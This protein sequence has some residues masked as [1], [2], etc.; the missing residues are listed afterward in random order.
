MRM[1]HDEH[2]RGYVANLNEVLDGTEWANR[3]LER[4]LADLDLLPEDKRTSVRNNGDD[5][6]SHTL[7]WEIMAP[8]GGGDPAGPLGDAIEAMFQSVRELKRQ[9]SAAGVAR[10]GSGWI[11]LMHDG[12]GLA[13]TYTPNQDSLPMNGH[14]PLLGV[15]V[16]GHAYY[17]KYQHRRADYLEAWWNVV[18]WERAADRYLTATGQSRQ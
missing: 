8:D 7:F 9:V 1:H 17:L 12:A 10:F 6:A 11:W 15:D 13:V 4:L 16:W 18:D 5:H 14:P 2:H 3:P